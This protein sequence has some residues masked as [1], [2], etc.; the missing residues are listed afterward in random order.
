M[1]LRP[2]VLMLRTGTN[3]DTGEEQWFGYDPLTPDRLYFVTNSSSIDEHG[4]SRPTDDFRE[5]EVWACEIVDDCT[6]IE[7]E[8][9]L[10]L[11]A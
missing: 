5:G 3:P 10:R 1:S 11:A 6:F 4:H 2:L 7:V 9:M 8:P